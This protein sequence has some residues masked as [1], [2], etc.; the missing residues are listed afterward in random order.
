M[1]YIKNLIM[2]YIIHLTCKQK[3]YEIVTYFCISVFHIPDYAIVSFPEENVKS[4][5]G[6]GSKSQFTFVSANLLL[7]IESVGKFQNMPFVYN[8]L[9]KCSKIQR[10]MQFFFESH[11]N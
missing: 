10:K 3:S 7:G 2:K 9:S 11:T 1:I 6:V 5:A 8:R 4:G